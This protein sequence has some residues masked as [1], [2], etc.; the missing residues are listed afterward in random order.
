MDRRQ[1]LSLMSLTA[2]GGLAGCDLLSNKPSQMRAQFGWLFDAHHTGFIIALR[3]GLYSKE[4]LTTT[5]LPGGADSNPIRS[6]VS[7]AAELG[8][9][10]G[11]EQIASALAE[12]LPIQPFAAIHQKT[13]HALISTSRTPIT[14]PADV[15]GKTVAVAFGDAAE[16]L[17]KAFLRKNGIAEDSVKLVPFRFDLTPL[18]TG[19]VDAI[20]GFRTD[21]PATIKAKG[22]TPVTLAYEDFGIDSYGYTLFTTKA[23]FAKNRSSIDHFVL[24]SRRGWEIAFAQPDV[25][26]NELQAF[27]GSPIDRVVEAEKLNLIRSIML[28]TD[29]SLAEWGTKAP[30][31]DGILEFLSAQGQIAKSAKLED[32]K[33]GLVF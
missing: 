30:K 18:L 9:A 29:G 12:G 20:T 15:V 33:R 24:A 14:K 11:I 4:A 10:G 22:Q 17:F 27:L 6:T 8:Q 5:L 3:Q 32:I 26:L 21:Q 28:N 25:A 7:G 13:P 2:L 16:I 31:V 19:N 1:V 23:E